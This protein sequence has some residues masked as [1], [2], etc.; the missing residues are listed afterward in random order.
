MNTSGK[1]KVGPE[2]DEVERCRKQ[3]RQGAHWQQEAPHWSALGA[4]GPAG[5]SVPNA[6]ARAEKRAGG[7]LGEAAPAPGRPKETQGTV[8]KTKGRGTAQSRALP[9]RRGG[10]R[11][12]RPR[13][14]CSQPGHGVNAATRQGGLEH[15]QPEP[16]CRNGPREED[17]AAGRAPRRAAGSRRV[18]LAAGRGSGGSENR[19]RAGTTA[20]AVAPRR[21]SEDRAP[22][23]PPQRRGVTTGR[24]A[25]GDLGR[26]PITTATAG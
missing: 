8:R 3:P 26:R 16:A 20:P 25:Q 22:S 11:R 15:R 5:A 1:K 17:A 4:P 12:W 19:A 13:P 2:C 7:R 14:G 23:R 9:P 21:E 24:R 6:R 18:P 10:E